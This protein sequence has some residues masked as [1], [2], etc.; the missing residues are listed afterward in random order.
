MNENHQKPL[1][2]IVAI[3]EEWAI[4]KNNDLLC[5]LPNDLKRFK[6]LTSGHK[7]LMGENTYISLPKRPLPNRTN[8]VLSLNP[9][10]KEEGIVI[11]RSLDEAI[12]NCDSESENF[13]MGG[14][15]I[16]RLFLPIATKL[17]LTRIHQKFEA[18]VFF[19]EINF[20]EFDLIES[21]MNPVSEENPIAYTYETWIRK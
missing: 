20:D 21:E 5:H 2:I 6:A 10:F 18:D 16:Y 1:C 9:E 8:I 4:G 12:E 17:Y 19:P 13:V 11:A 3:A 7:V 14:G 15:M